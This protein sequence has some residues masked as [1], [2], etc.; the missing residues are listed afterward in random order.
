MID[1]ESK[2]ISE[3]KTALATDYPNLPLYSTMTRIP[4]KMP[5]AC[6]EEI[7]N[8]IHKNAMTTSHIE[9]VA[10]VTYEVNVYS[11]KKTGK[12][13]ECKAIFQIIDETLSDM[14]FIREYTKPVTLDSG[15]VYQYIARYTTLATNN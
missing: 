2:V 15:T 3:I 6:V 13:A 12:K 7:D 10:E 11:N 9:N 1:I 4:E 5:C 14:G 8:Y